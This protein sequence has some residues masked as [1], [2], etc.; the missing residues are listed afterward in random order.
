MTT[1]WQRSRGS[2]DSQ[3]GLWWWLGVTFILWERFPPWSELALPF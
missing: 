1:T 3:F 2:S